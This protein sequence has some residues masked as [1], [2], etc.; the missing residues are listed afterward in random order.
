M[1]NE[2]WGRLCKSAI[3]S[4]LTM[5]STN[6]QRFSLKIFL[7]LLV[8]FHCISQPVLSLSS[9]E[10]C[11]NRTCSG[12]IAGSLSCQEG[13]LT[14]LPDSLSSDIQ[15]MILMGHKFHNPILTNDNFSTYA[16]QN[17]K[18][19]RL[20]LRNCGIQSIQPG[21]FQSLKSLQQL[22]LSQNKVKSIRKGT[23]V[24]LHLDF[25]RLDENFGLSIEEGAFEGTSVVSLSINQCGLKTLRYD[26]LLP[27]INSKQLKNLHLS[28]N[29]LITLESRLEPIFIQLQS[30]SLEQNPFKC[31]C[32]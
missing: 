6:H 24:G 8:I 20:T 22:D 28:G 18:L 27:L 12:C 16:Q 11:L 32:S 19:Q 21:T 15:S 13:G 3:A 17:V 29:Q 4:T 23:F 9:N 2:K 31:D 25:L 14:H 7:L 1:I 5:N 10:L 30:L 26:T